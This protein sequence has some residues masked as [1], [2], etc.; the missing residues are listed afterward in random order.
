MARHFNGSSD[1]ATAFFNFGATFPPTTNIS[2]AAWVWRDNLTAGRMLLEQGNTIGIG[3]DVV[4]NAFA[5]PQDLIRSFSGSSSWADS[6]TPPAPGAWHHHVW[7]FPLG[8]FKPNQV[9]IDGA[10][11]ALTSQGHVGF[12]GHYDNDVISFAARE[13]SGV[14]SLWWAGR[15]AEIGLWTDAIDA[16]NALALS[17]GSPPPFAFN[18]AQV[19]Y[20]PFLGDPSPEPNYQ[21]GQEVATLVGST[22]VNHPGVRSLMGVRGPRGG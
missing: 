22:V 8:G 17:Q 14:A 19:G 13:T 9:Y 2:V 20:W 4:A 7:V 21:P 16:Q 11:V 5:G 12:G 1:S 3:F 10:A 15:L 18:E 6:Y